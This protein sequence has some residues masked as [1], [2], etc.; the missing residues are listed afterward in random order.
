MT[1]LWNGLLRQL[2]ARFPKARVRVTDYHWLTKMVDRHP[3]L[4]GFKNASDACWHDIGPE[5]APARLSAPRD[6][7]P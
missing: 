4:F 5:V 1:A 7:G 3:E 6:A 2:P